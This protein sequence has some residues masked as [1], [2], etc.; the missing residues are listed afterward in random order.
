A[1]STTRTDRTRTTT[2]P[3]RRQTP[4]RRRQATRN[5]RRVRRSSRLTTRR[6]AQT[7]QT[8][9]PRLPLGARTRRP[10]PRYPPCRTRGVRTSTRRA[11][12]PMALFSK[13][14]DAP[15]DGVD[16]LLADLDGIVYAG[17]GA[18]PHAIESLNRAESDGRRLGY[19]T[20]NASRT[21]ASVAQHLVDLGLRTRPE[22][23]V[24]S[25]QAAVQLLA[26]T[27]PSGSTVL[28]VGG[29]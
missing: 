23:V 18:V 7:M 8:P 19:I 21:D 11:T 15:L 6:A 16:V 12:A 3:S 27:V 17:P 14:T 2:C 4:A 24:T 10:P 9:R 29:E 5:L 28:V 25:P 20:N 13:K 1:S 22:D 26:K